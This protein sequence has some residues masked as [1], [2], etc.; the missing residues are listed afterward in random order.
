MKVIN[1]EKSQ[2]I[3]N[4]KERCEWLKTEKERNNCQRGYHFQTQNIR[5]HTSLVLVRRET[6]S[7]FCLFV[8]TFVCFSTYMSYFTHLHIQRLQTWEVWLTITKEV[9]REGRSCRKSTGPLTLL[10][11]ENG[12]A[13]WRS[14]KEN[15]TE[16]QRMLGGGC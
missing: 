15:A 10:T 8:F 6:R 5:W 1:K 9:S 14:Q 11:M 12:S 7:V 2:K 3:P 16:V 13:C 4:H